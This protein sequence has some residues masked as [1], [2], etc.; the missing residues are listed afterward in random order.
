MPRVP[1]G[2]MLIA[3]VE[4]TSDRYHLAAVGLRAPV[5]WRQPAAAA[6]AAVHAQGGVAI[7]AHPVP[8]LA[9]GFDAAALDALDGFEAAHP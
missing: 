9:D 4:L 3:G 8:P 5:A 7:A 1:T 6:A 2:A